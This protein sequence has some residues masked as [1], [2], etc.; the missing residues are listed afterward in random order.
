[1]K[2]TKRFPAYLTVMSGV[3]SRKTEKSKGNVQ[4]LSFFVE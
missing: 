4:T 3:R 1:M 2:E